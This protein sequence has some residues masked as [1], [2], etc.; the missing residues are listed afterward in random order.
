MIVVDTDYLTLL[1]WKEHPKARL[2]YEELKKRKETLTTTIVSFEEQIRG[3]LSYLAQAKTV[4]KQIEVYGLLGRN[5]E[6]FC[7]MAILPFDENAAAKYQ[8]NKRLRLRIGSMDERIAAIVIANK[9]TLLTRNTKDFMR[10]PGLMIENWI[11]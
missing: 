11:K 9:A 8:E 10:V 4:A 5:V 6:L 3:W 1:E 7:G 2:V